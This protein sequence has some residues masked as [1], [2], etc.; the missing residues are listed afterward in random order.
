VHSY[1]DHVDAGSHIHKGCC[2]TVLSICD[3]YPAAV[4][5]IN[6][7]YFPCA[8][9][10]PTLAIDINLLEFV[11]LASH[12]MAP[13]VMGWSNTLQEFLSIHGYLLGAKVQ[14][15][16]IPP[17]FHV[18]SLYWTFQDSIQQ[19]FGNALHWYQVLVAIATHEVDTWIQHATSTKPAAA[20]TT[21]AESATRDIPFP[22][23]KVSHHINENEPHN[24]TP[25]I[26]L[27]KRC[28]VCFS[29]G[30]P[31]FRTSQCVI[32]FL[33]MH[34]PVDISQQGTGHC[35]P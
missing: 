33:S 10:R 28:P 8:P 2:S 30:K 4:Q 25:S 29:G 11:T 27:Q 14:G 24:S 18:L 15:L 9:V 31:E 1:L 22:L 7:G 19:R 34:L 5:L 26:Y 13:N 32:I 17:M 12:N 16:F 21:C 3:C 23:S 6:I 20:P 35:M